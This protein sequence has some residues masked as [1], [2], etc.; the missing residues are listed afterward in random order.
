MGRLGQFYLGDWLVADFSDCLLYDC[1][2]QA[3]TLSV[4][5]EVLVFLVYLHGVQ[6]AGS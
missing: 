3:V 1:Q 6:V 5:P 2:V 4:S